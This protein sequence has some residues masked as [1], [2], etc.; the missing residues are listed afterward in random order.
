MEHVPRVPEW[1]FQPPPV[2]EASPT[3]WFQKNKVEIL[4]DW[5]WV[6]AV[7]FDLPWQRGVEDEPEVITDPSRIV[8][9]PG[10]GGCTEGGLG[11]SRP[12]LHPPAGDR[13]PSRTHAN[14]V[15]VFV[16]VSGK[17]VASSCGEHRTAALE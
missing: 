5:N 12:T 16:C 11:P 2:S 10:V 13:A 6:S 17:G 7:Q 4:P 9:W 14:G 3:L 1:Y 8:L 15:C